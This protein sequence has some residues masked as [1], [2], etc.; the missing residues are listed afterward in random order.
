MHSFEKHIGSCRLPK[1]KE[2]NWLGKTKNWDSQWLL[3]SQKDE[4]NTK[5]EE[6]TC[7]RM[8][9]AKLVAAQ[10]GFQG[11]WPREIICAENIVS[12]GVPGSWDNDHILFMYR[13]PFTCLEFLSNF[14]VL[15]FKKT[16]PL[17]TVLENS[18]NS[19][20]FA[21][22]LALYIYSRLFPLP[23]LLI[24]AFL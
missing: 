5:S 7:L 19:P 24:N 9:H 13:I 8:F 4:E 21:S 16:P 3:R 11:T 23:L 15:L 14:E 20:L 1:P 17:T 10:S 18:L 2:P 22:F 6:P 12:S